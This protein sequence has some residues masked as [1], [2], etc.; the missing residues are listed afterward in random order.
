MTSVGVAAA[1][2]R[3][4]AAPARIAAAPAGV[5]VGIPA[6]AAG[7]AAGY[8]GV[9]AGDAARGAARVAAATRA[10]PL[11]IAR[12]M[13]HNNFCQCAE[14]PYYMLGKHGC[15]ASAKLR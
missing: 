7:V 8:A 2:A 4:A 3:V 15:H 11:P 5:A 13:A 1:P 10:V 14:E 6:S 9:S 12:K